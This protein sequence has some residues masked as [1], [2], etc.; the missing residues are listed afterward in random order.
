MHA[1]L[2][3]CMPAGERIADRVTWDLFYLWRAILVAAQSA[4]LFVYH[5]GL[6]VANCAEAL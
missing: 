4:S 5:E 2:W 6:S 1:M 3:L